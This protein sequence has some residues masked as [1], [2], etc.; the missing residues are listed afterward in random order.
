MLN[1]YKLKTKIASGFIFILILTCLVSYVGWDGMGKIGDRVEKADD[2]NQMIKTILQA[3]RHEKNF[4]I[5]GDTKYIQ[6]VKKEIVNLKDLA[7]NTR[8]K[9]KDPLNQSQMDEVL[10]AA[11][12]YEQAF[13]RIVELNAKKTEQRVDLEKGFREIDEV[14]IQTGRTVE[15]KANE[16]QLNQKK[17]ME[18]KMTQAKTLMIAGAL[19]AVILGLTAAFFIIRSITKPI[20]KVIEGLLEDA[21]KVSA[22][23]I[24]V[25]SASQSL[26]EGASE[27]ASGLEETSASMEEMSSMTK[28]NADHARQAKIMMGEVQGIVKKVN[29]HMDQMGQAITEITRTSEETGKIIKTI[30]EIAF[31]TNLLALNAAVEAA[32]AGEAGAGF[33]VVADEVRNLAMRAAEAAKNTSNLIENTITAIKKGNELTVATRD[34]F[35]ENTIV[36]GKISNL[37]DEIASASEEQSQGINQVS[38]AVGEMDRIVQ[39]NAAAAEESAAAS[40]ELNVQAAQMKDMVDDLVA[41]VEGLEQRKNLGP[42]VNPV[43]LGGRIST[44]NFKDRPTVRVKTKMVGKK[45]KRLAG[46]MD[47]KT[48][49]LLPLEK[50]IF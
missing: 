50:E 5:R 29:T 28:Q 34:A 3:R 42:R 2:T 12:R 31:Q 27:Q 46:E 11:D 7:S 39:Q 44:H 10:A 48:R 17:K 18:A 6:E 16:A 33:A 23:S 37:I 19:A 15:G 25:S 49:R 41:L 43:E 35:Q 24:Q 9:F 4:I 22:S 30:D 8:K 26:A 13:N 1:R 21:E 14:L 20:R 32:R 47:S 38:Q 40:E 45:F 36:A